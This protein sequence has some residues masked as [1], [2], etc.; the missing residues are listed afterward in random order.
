MHNTRIGHLRNSSRNFTKKNLNFLLLLD[1]VGLFVCGGGCVW[2]TISV[3]LTSPVVF[4][5]LCSYFPSLL[6]TFPPF[7]VLQSIVLPSN[8][9][10]AP[11]NP[12]TPP[13]FTSFS[14][15]PNLSPHYPSLLHIH[16]LLTSLLYKQ[17]TTPVPWNPW[18][19]QP[20]LQQKKYTPK[21]TRVTKTSSPHTNSPTHLFTTPSLV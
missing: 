12:L 3:L 2:F 5:Y 6:L 13:V 19:K 10:S 8:N 20:P 18:H 4:S 17:Y 15:P 1:L 9:F 21:Y 7:P 16:H 11:S 14:Y